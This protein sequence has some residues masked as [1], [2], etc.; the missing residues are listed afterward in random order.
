MD[1]WDRAE[2]ILKELEEKI[3]A[4]P[5]DEQQA[6]LGIIS[7]ELQSWLEAIETGEA[8]ADSGLAPGHPIS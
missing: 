1:A 8:A 6:V 5:E 4:I 3:A 7:K 2:P